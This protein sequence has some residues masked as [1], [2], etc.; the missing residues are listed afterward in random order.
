LNRIYIAGPFLKGTLI[1]CV[2]TPGR[3][4]VSPLPVS[5]PI[6]VTLQPSEARSSACFCTLI[7][8]DRSLITAINTLIFN[9]LNDRAVLLINISD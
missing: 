9:L 1:R 3:D 4:S 6:T 5:L 2:F 7:S 8:V